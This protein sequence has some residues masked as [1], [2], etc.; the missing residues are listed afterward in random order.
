VVVSLDFDPILEYIS[1][2]LRAGVIDAHRAIFRDV[3]HKERGKLEQ[4]K[5]NHAAESREA[6]R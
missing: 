1:Y 4:R 5:R 6:C 2:D 3:P